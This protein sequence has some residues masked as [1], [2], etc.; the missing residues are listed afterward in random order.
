MI[1]IFLGVG[2]TV[3]FRRVAASLDV[4][5]QRGVLHGVLHPRGLP[6]VRVHLGFSQKSVWVDHGRMRTRIVFI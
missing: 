2:I 1:I 5:E 6:S 4:D 3:N